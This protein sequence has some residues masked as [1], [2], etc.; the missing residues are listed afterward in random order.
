M[1][2]G[3]QVERSG[4]RVRTSTRGTRVSLLSHLPAALPPC[5][6]LSPCCRVLW[7]A[8]GHGPLH[9]KESENDQ[10]LENGVFSTLPSPG[11]PPELLLRC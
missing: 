8:L 5:P 10:I 9:S 1:G 2:S 6:H 4:P 3:A 7:D 11:S